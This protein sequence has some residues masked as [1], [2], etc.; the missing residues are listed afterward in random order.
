MIQLQKMSKI[1]SILSLICLAALLTGGLYSLLET[2]KPAQLLN[3][4]DPNETQTGA[5]IRRAACLQGELPAGVMTFGYLPELPRK[6]EDPG[7]SSS[8]L[9]RQS[10]NYQTY[11]LTQFALAPV[12][13]YHYVAD[14]WIIAHYPTYQAGL[15]ALGQTHFQIV[16]DCGNGVF[17]V[18]K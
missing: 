7:I 4:P 1:R 3:P 9:R 6:M 18:R 8:I 5:L 16:K 11:F 2:F 14:Q 12:V 17:L 10:N 15:D 13:I